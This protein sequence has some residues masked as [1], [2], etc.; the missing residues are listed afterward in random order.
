LEPELVSRIDE[1][2]DYFSAAWRD[3]TRSDVIRA[4][5]LDALERFERAHDASRGG[6]KG[7]GAKGGAAKGGAAKGGAKGGGAKAAPSLPQAST[8]K[9]GRKKSESNE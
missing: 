4:L 2:R 5:L 6:A 3:A 7:A 1:L 9:R 8:A